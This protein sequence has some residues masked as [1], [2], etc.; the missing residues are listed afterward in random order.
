MDYIGYASYFA[1]VKY[2]FTG[3]Y[4]LLVGLH[5]L[6]VANRVRFPVGALGS[7]GRLPIGRELLAVSGP[8]I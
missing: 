1:E 6:N 3:S 2:L 5:V 7:V 8:I 4:R